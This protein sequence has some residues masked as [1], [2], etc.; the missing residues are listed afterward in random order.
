MKDHGYLIRRFLN[1]GLAR[2]QLDSASGRLF[3]P[4]ECPKI[5]LKSLLHLPKCTANLYTSADAVQ[6]CG[7]FWDTQ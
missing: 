4:T 3:S 6:S 7:T 2:L 1:K 5:Y